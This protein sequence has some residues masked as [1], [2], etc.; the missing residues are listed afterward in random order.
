MSGFI[1]AYDI[2]STGCKTCLYRFDAAGSSGSSRADR[3]FSL[4]LAGS[5]LAGYELRRTDSGGVEQ[6]PDDWWEAMRATTGE[7]LAEAGASP[8]D[9]KGISFCAQMQGLVLVDRDLKPVRPAMSYL[10][11]RA[12]GELREVLGKGIKIEGM[13]AFKL[14]QSLSVNGAIA[15]SAKDPVWKYRWVRRFER[16]A[17]SRVYKWLD[18]KDYLTARA[19]GVCTMTKDSAFATFLTEEKKGILRWSPSM[20]RMYGV[21]PAHLPPII[22]ATDRAGVLAAESARELGLE[23][24]TPVFGGGGDA[25]LTGVGAGAVEPNDCYVYTGTSGWVSCVVDKRVTDVSTRA[26]SIVGAIGGFYN[27]FAEQETAGKCLEWVRDHL[28]KDEIDLYLDKQSVVDGPE[29]RYRSMYDFLLES[30]AQVP[31][32]SGGVIFAPW[33]HGNR[34]PFEDPAARGIFFNIG[35]DTG[36][37][38]LIRSVVEGIMLHQRWLLDSVKKKFPVSGPLR[39]A[40]GGALSPAMA[41]ILADVLGH[42]VETVEHPQNCG[43]SG[44]AWCAAVGLGWLAGFG[45]VKKSVRV[46]GR[47]EPNPAAAAVYG[48]HYDVFKKL[49][50]RNRALFADLNGEDM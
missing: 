7:A 18:V 28:A 35:L 9:V 34:C 41:Q 23:P 43:A 46:T 15:A 5:A 3:S 14:I 26:A 10:D 2:G 33:L 48:R 17:F 6:N 49:Y 8:A 22:G 16:E 37:R 12:E 45:E 40:G 19:C 30:I 36:K 29:S 25:S 38:A 21:D 44:A 47:Y 13:N 4:T 50:A 39:F 42:P 31:P 11:Q 24:G 32:G 20:L 1:I 27:Y